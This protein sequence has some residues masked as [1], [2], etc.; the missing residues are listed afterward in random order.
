MSFANLLN[1]RQLTDMQ[2][3]L[4]TRRC[5]D[6]DD[7]V[8]GESYAVY[9]DG[10]QLGCMKK[11]SHMIDDTDYAIVIF[12]GRR[13]GK[14]RREVMFEGIFASM[15]DCLDQAFQFLTVNA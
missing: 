14:R 15:R 1:H 7:T 12:A 3:E 6:W 10:M 8:G 13:T 9:L 4:T 5:F 11:V 2:N